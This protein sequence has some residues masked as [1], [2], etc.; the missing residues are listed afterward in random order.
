M[1]ASKSFLKENPEK[2]SWSL[3]TSFWKKNYPTKSIYSFGTSSLD[4]QKP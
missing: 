3:K 1:E 4:I 2:S